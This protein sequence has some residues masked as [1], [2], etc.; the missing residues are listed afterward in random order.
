MADKLIFEPL[1]FN[2]SRE[3]TPLVRIDR[4]AAN[5]IGEIV[6]KTGLSKSFIASE[7]I[8]Y[9]AANVEISPTLA[10]RKKIKGITIIIDSDDAE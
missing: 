4:E 9:A 1:C 2:Q 5:C 6:N 7:M 8:K 3:E 10:S